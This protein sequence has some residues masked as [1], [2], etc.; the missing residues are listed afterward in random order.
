MTRLGLT[1][2]GHLNVLNYQTCETRNGKVY[3]GRTK[4][5]NPGKEKIFGLAKPFKMNLKKS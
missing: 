2:T 3:N 4:I 5:I 1:N